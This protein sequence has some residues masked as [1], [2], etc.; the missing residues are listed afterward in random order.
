[1]RASPLC[2]LGHPNA[3]TELNV[4]ITAN[5]ETKLLSRRKPHLDDRAGECC[6][7]CNKPQPDVDVISATHG[8]IPEE[9]VEACVVPKHAERVVAET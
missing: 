8:V 2:P 5:N 6:I 3:K 9:L 7:G 1:M 4:T